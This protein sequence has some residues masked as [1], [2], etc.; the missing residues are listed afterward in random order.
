MPAGS[1]PDL[2]SAE[3]L[4]RIQQS[5]DESQALSLL[6]SW[7]WDVES[8]SLTWSAQTFR[9]FGLEPGSIEP[10]F[11]DYLSRVHADDRELVKTSVRTAVVSGQPF[12]YY[13]RI[14]RPDGDIRTLHARGG[15]VKD[16]AGTSSRMLGT[17][18]DVT[19]MLKLQ[20]E[21]AELTAEAAASWRLKFLSDGTDGLYATMDYES[22]LAELARYVV[23]AMAD[24]CAVDI[25]QDDGSF[26][27]LAVVHSDPAKVRMA[28]EVEKE[29][30]EDTTQPTSRTQVLATG[31]PAFIPD[32]SPEMIDL[33]AK[34]ARHAELI[35]SLGLRS[36]ITVPLIARGQKLGTLTVVMA[37]SGRNY[38]ELDLALVKE[39]GRRSAVAIDNARL[40]REMQNANAQLQ[41]L[42]EEQQVMNE[43]LTAQ[44][45]EM[46]MAQESLRETANQLEE[47]NRELTNAEARYKFLADSIPVQVWTALP[48][49]SIDYMSAGAEQF[50][51]RPAETLVRSGWAQ[52]L[53]P[54]DFERISG[55]WGRSLSTGEPYEVEIRLLGVHNEYAWHLVR[56]AP[57]RDE[58]GKIVRWFGTNTN[59]DAQKRLSEE[60]ERLKHEAQA[61]N[62]A[63][64]EFLAAMS[65]E[66][67][68]PL[69]AISG[70][71]DL[72]LMEIPGTLVPEQRDFVARI[73]RSGKFLLG[74]IN[75]VLSFAKIDA[76]SVH[77]KHVAIN[78]DD[79]LSG[80]HT[81]VEPQIKLKKQSYVYQCPD[82][83]CVVIGDHEKI[84][85]VV[86]NLLVNS[87][88]FTRVGGAI[89]LSCSSGNGL[90]T[91]AVTDNGRGI[92]VDHL[93][94]IFDPFVQVDRKSNEFSQQGVGLGLAI[95]REL[96][97]AMGGDLTVESTRGVGSTFTLTLPAK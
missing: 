45:I 37:E 63:K 73:Q 4:R 88:K 21:R 15:T 74:I 36:A 35:H 72:L 8:G 93:E 9:N 81:L 26:K 6:G 12:D 32:I 41:D 58:A 68:T 7:E 76:G 50:F 80:I 55:Q 83:D 29:Y 85:Q 44:A 96:A 52:F 60:R 5:L 47:S 51:G 61:A 57:Q 70:Y 22:R 17:G 54:D 53:H 28:L 1:H 30:P 23:P 95:S 39:L 14:V 2:A 64:M 92:D 90:A 82:K 19:E 75:D 11:D 86:L 31:I 67:R 78:I 65:H 43:T 27:R 97:Q 42:L 40:H 56:S 20:A 91:I 46:E 87:S 10:S 33:L 71:T 13:H 34:D 66:L 79:V 77:V 25:V 24:W 18:Q 94:T 49:G 59:I 16:G 62:R 89:T 69:N 38:D 48:D 84:E 3:K